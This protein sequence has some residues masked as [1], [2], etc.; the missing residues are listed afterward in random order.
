MCETTIAL[1]SVIPICTAIIAI[2]TLEA[3]NLSQGNNGTALTAIIALIA[4][5][6][7][8]KAGQLITQKKKH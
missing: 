2:T 5:L 8:V 7:G 3:I 4:G 6:G 1:K